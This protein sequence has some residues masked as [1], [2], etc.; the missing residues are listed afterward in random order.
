[1]EKKSRKRKHSKNRLDNFGAK[2]KKVE[3]GS[4]VVSGEL[5]VE[6][7]LTYANKPKRKRPFWKEKKNKNSQKRSVHNNEKDGKQNHKQNSEIT[8]INNAIRDN[9]KMKPSLKMQNL[10]EKGYPARSTELKNT[11]VSHCNTTNK[12]E[13]DEART[14]NLRHEKPEKKKEFKKKRKSKQMSG[15]KVTSSVSVSSNWKKLAES[16]NFKTET[17]TAVKPRSVPVKPVEQVQDEKKRAESPEIW[18]DDVDPMVLQATAATASSNSQP[19]SGYE[20][21]TRCIAMDCEMVGAGFD[22]KDNELARVSLV[23]EYGGCVY[24]KYVKPR[25]KVTD[26]RTAVSGIT[27]AHIRKA[28]EFDVVQRDVADMLKGRILVGHALNNDMK[29]LYLSHQRIN[30]RDTARYKPFQKIMRTNRPG[31]K[32]L[33]KKIL[34]MDVQQGEHNSVEDAQAAMKLYML[35]R[36]EWDSVVKRASIKQQ[37]WKK[38][39]R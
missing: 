37:T 12:T 25:E 8:D 16:M 26:Y 9:T 29:V 6:H 4:V 14:K 38:K 2:K 20:G 35:H 39:R 5:K 15:E 28:E 18:F 7:N 27:P 10:N 17:K 23:N 36:K 13:E 33:T 1:M 34:K 21:L 19:K 22:G 31:L 30:V 11:G 3:S 32:K 24:D